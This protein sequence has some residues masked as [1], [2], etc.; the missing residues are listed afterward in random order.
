MT[1][2]EYNPWLRPALVALTAAVAAFVIYSIGRRVVLRVTRWSQMLDHIVRAVDPAARFMLPLIA[3]EGVFHGADDKLVGIDAVRHL[4]GILLIATF[5]WLGIAAVKGLGDGII[6]RYPY[7][8][9]DNLQA[10]RVLTQTRVL[11]RTAMAV[12][13]VAGLAFILMTFP[14]VRQLGASLLASAGVAG[15]VAGIAAKSVFSNLIAGLQIAL[16]QPIRIDDV[17]V[18]NGEWGRVEEIT[19]TYVVLKIWDERRL[20]IPLQ[21]FIENPFQNWTRSSSEL[22]GT[23]MLW[24]DF[25]LPL[26]PIRDEAKRLCEASK[27]WDRRICFVQVVDATDRAMQVRILVTSAN[28]SMNFDLRCEV[29][30]G[31]IAFIAREHP[32]ALPRLRAELDEQTAMPQPLPPARLEAV[33]QPEPVV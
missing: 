13:G 21:W 29:R 26:D 14:G 1:W 7:D 18:I 15:L 19:G 25:S 24:V 28:S 4:N 27:N 12:L 9:A 5:T 3:L 10:R 16:S 31:L 8:V 20:I 32:E 2:L 6:A 33:R 23:V 11:G 30:E 22:I 17:L